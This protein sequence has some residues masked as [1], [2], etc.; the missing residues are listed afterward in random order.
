[1][2]PSYPFDPELFELGKPCR[3]RHR[4][5][6]SRLCLRYI[7][8]A[9]CVECER[10]RK[11]G[12]T[13]YNPDKHKEQYARKSQDAAWKNERLQYMRAISRKPEHAE[14]RRQR[15]EEIREAN[16]AAGLTSA[17]TVRT[18]P[19]ST[20]VQASIRNA[21]RLPTVYQLVRAEQLRYW[22]EN[23]QE[24]ERCK[25]ERKRERRLWRYKIDASMRIYNREKS[26][27]R[28]AVQRG[29]VGVHVTAAQIRDRFNEFGN[30]CAY[31]GSGGD[32]HIEHVTPIAKG[33]NHVLSNILPAC[34][35][36]NY[37]KRTHPVEEWYRSQAFFCAKRW[38]KIRRVLGLRNGSANQLSLL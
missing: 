25:K 9:K 36:C 34:Q 1:M 2:D 11:H 15:K 23:P 19:G 20:R 27:R 33:G 26:K 14:K 37:S 18:R 16:R 21:G 10:A 4:W 13:K 24:A 38:G 12:K 3:K 31:C 5:Q 30:L 6:D 7:K 22:K 29:S 28:K 32:L 8:G 35:R 17:G